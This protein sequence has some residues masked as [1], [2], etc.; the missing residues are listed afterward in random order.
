MGDKKCFSSIGQFIKYFDSNG[1]NLYFNFK[2]DGNYKSTIGGL[3]YLIFILASTGYFIYHFNRYFIKREQFSLYYSSGI[4]PGHV[5]FTD[6]EIQVGFG[7]QTENQ[8]RNYDLYEYVDINAKLKKK[9]IKN[10]NGTNEDYNTNLELVKCTEESFFH[11]VDDEF[12]ITK[13]DNFFCLKNISNIYLYGNENGSNHTYIQFSVS[14]KDKY[15]N[16]SDIIKNF[17]FAHLS[18]R[19]PP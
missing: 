18:R 4:R 16:N 6:E 19:I 7:L 1:A 11:K 14:I 17:P 5:N 9:Y 2:R 13:F 10:K 15:I 3:T 12:K 8:E